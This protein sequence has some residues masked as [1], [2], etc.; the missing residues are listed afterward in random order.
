MV[1][2][3]T[4]EQQQVV[5]QAAVAASRLAGTVADYQ[6]FASDLGA[7]LSDLSGILL[8]VVASSPV[9]RIPILACTPKDLNRLG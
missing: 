7:P 9:I 3:S 5:Q 1:I 2:D 8:P 6:A 4:Q